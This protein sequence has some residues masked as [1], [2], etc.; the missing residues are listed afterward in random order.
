MLEKI[1]SLEEKIFVV[2][3]ENANDTN[4]WDI[5]TLGP[6][7][8]FTKFYHCALRVPDQRDLEWWSVE[9][10]DEKHMKTTQ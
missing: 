8:K 6:C 10:C 2:I 3:V 7:T 9:L 4:I 5:Q 1:P